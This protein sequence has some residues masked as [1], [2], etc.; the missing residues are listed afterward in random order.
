MKAKL[1][2]GFPS[3]RARFEAAMTTIANG[4]PTARPNKEFPR[5]FFFA[6]TRTAESRIGVALA[7][8][9]LIVMRDGTKQSKPQTGSTAMTFVTLFSSFSLAL[10]KCGLLLFRD[11]RPTG[12]LARAC[13]K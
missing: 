6:V 1:A 5:F 10:D 3:S 4:M 12:G 13:K 11:A 7:D 2:A 8:V 9:E